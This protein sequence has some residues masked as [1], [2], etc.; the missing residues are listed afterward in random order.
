MSRWGSQSFERPNQGKTRTGIHSF[1]HTFFHERQT[2]SAHVLRPKIGGNQRLDFRL[3]VPNFKYHRRRTQRHG[4]RGSH[5]LQLPLLRRL[6][7]LAN[8][9]FSKKF[10]N[11][12][13]PQSHV[14]N[15]K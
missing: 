10:A 8:E 1:W 2:L 12:L 5:L 3:Q 11:H 6:R 15:L 14:P 4:Q 7:S 13:V 9:A